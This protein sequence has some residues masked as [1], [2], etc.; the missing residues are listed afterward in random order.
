MPSACRAVA[1][2]RAVCVHWHV[3]RLVDA[4]QHI[5]VVQYA[6]V[7]GDAWFAMLLL[8]TQAHTTAQLFVPGRG[9][10]VE[11][12]ATLFEFPAPLVYRVVTKAL[13]QEAEQ[14]LAGSI[15]GDA[16]L[17]RERLRFGG[18]HRRAGHFLF[19]FL[20][21]RSFG[22]HLLRRLQSGSG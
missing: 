20:M 14:V 22:E 3:G 2:E 21:L 19:G 17:Q 15:V 13:A 4:H 9:D 1:N 18:R 8:V 5:V 12:Y 11:R 16:R 6:E 10:A 7:G